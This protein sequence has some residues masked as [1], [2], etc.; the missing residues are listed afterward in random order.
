MEAD[1]SWS[2][3]NSLSVMA[4]PVRYAGWKSWSA[5]AATATGTATGGRGSGRLQR[6][7]QRAATGAAAAADVRCSQRR[8]D[9]AC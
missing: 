3:V 1:L 8:H 2:S 7:Y 6:Q 5:L 9:Q 4:L